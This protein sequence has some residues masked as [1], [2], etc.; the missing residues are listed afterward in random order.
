M[1]CKCKLNI[2]TLL[3]LLD[4]LDYLISGE[5]IMINVL[6]LQMMGDKNN[7]EW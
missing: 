2:L 1:F 3:T 5:D 4:P 7:D 6:L